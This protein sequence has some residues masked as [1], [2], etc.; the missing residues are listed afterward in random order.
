[1]FYILCFTHGVRGETW[2]YSYYWQPNNSNN[3]NNINIPT[4]TRSINPVGPRSSSP[5]QISFWRVRWTDGRRV[6]AGRTYIGEGVNE[7][8]RRISERSR[9]R[10]S[11]DDKN[12][13]Q[14]T[15]DRR[16]HTVVYTTIILYLRHINDPP[17]RA[18]YREMLIILQTLL[19]GT[20]MMLQQRHKHRFPTKNCT[21]Y[22]LEKWPYRAYWNIEF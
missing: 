16:R 5:L 15:S 10:C 9:R 17:R 21:K 3:K 20:G 11:R 18:H 12:K 7:V 8:A 6:G 4:P 1:M 14:V 2:P 22:F 13:L 19:W